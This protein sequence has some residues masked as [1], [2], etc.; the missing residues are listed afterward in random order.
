MLI[1]LFYITVIKPNIP[2]DQ[3]PQGLMMLKTK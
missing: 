1:L 2:L 3:F